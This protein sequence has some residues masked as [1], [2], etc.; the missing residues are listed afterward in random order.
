MGIEVLDD[1][2]PTGSPHS[3]EKS[4]WDY[5]LELPTLPVGRKPTESEKLTYA[6]AAA[7]IVKDVVAFYNSCG[8][9]LVVG[10][11]DKTRDVVGFTTRFDCSDLAKKTLGATKQE[12]DCH[13]KVH[14]VQLNRQKIEV[15][16][17][18]IPRRPD[19]L[20][21]AQFRQDAPAAANGKVA[22]RKGQIYLR[23]GD[24]SRPADASEDYSF[25]CSPERRQVTSPDATA[26]R[27]ALD[28]NLGPRD[29]G[30]IKFVGR[31][32]YLRSLWQWMCDPFS[33]VKLLSGIGGVGKTT[34]A[35][36]FV[37]DLIATPPGGLERVIWLSAKLH[38]FTAILGEYNPTSRLDFTD[39]CSL[40]QA[41]LR[42]LGYPDKTINAEWDRD[43]L[44]QEVVQALKLFP[45]LIVVDDVDSLKPEHQ[46]DV[47][48]SMI[49]IVDQT[50]AGTS[51]PSRVLLT[52][53]LDLGA[54]PS[55]LV[56]VRGLDL[57]DFAE[58]VQMTAESHGMT[59]QHK[60]NAPIVKRFHG[61]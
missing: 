16:L 5:K 27:M 22:Y 40:L 52:A 50:L 58:Y 45:C 29:P 19:S 14:S 59:W 3:Y 42:E 13:Y 12:I 21:P 23:Q 44:I 28:N 25:L 53:R 31:E 11:N 51:M 4:L 20:D 24:C 41:M 30:F 60:P 1:L 43:D 56:R 9:Y 8:G 26:L 47:F 54:A 48:H 7:E 57:G 2:L 35:R 17:L 18:L 38:L 34:L 61:C 37:E 39:T 6:A 15:G 10:V 33:P 55:Q 49:R 32:T 46:Q 36:E